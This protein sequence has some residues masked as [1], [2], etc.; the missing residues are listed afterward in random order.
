MQVVQGKYEYYNCGLLKGWILGS[1]RNVEFVQNISS[2]ARTLW[3]NL[4][5]VDMVHPKSH[6]PTLKQ[7][8]SSFCVLEK[9]YEAPPVTFLKVFFY[10]LIIHSN[11]N[12]GLMTKIRA[13]Q[14]SKW[15]IR[16][17]RH[18]VN[19]NTHALWKG[20]VW[21]WKNEAPKTHK[22]IFTLGVESWGVPNLC[23]RFGEPNFDK[24]GP[25][26]MVG[27]VLKKITIKWGCIVKLLTKTCNTSYWNWKGRKSN[28]QND[29][30]SLNQCL[31]RFNKAYSC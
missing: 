23:S 2:N 13:W 6:R 28:C 25:F 12:L 3:W 15:A 31:A 24:I 30:Q 22:C 14:G 21:E 18:G 19:L 10:T 4:W 20:G 9:L 26:L 5:V 27:N 17:P 29:F 1:K 8:K 11:L 16:S 7:K